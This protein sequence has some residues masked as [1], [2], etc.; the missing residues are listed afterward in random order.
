[1]EDPVAKAKAIAARMS[2][3]AA[4]IGTTAASSSLK[5][6]S[7]GFSAYGPAGEAA[8]SSEAPKRKRW[9]GTAD[10]SSGSDAG[11]RYGDKSAVETA[12]V[13]L[14]E[15]QKRLKSAAQKRV[16]VNVTGDRPAS[17]YRRYWN[18]VQKPSVVN[19]E[20]MQVKLQGR[21]SSGQPPLP[22]VP[23]EPMHVLLE[24]PSAEALEPHVLSVEM[25]LQQAENAELMPDDEPPANDGTAGVHGV[26]DSEIGQGQPGA[27]GGS[28]PSFNTGSGG[29]GELASSGSA[30]RPAP[31][32][33]LIN[34][35]A[36]PPPSAGGDHELLNEQMSVPNGVVGYIIGRGGESISSM[37]ART[38]AKV[39]IQKERDMQPGQGLRI[40]TIQ[41]T[42]KEAIDACRSIIDTMVTERVRNNNNNNGGA[43]GNSTGGSGGTSQE[44]RLREAIA[45]GHAVVQ[46]EIP[47][48][49]VG[50]IIGRGGSTIK[51]IQ[52]RSGA[53]VQIPQAGDPS[54]PSVRTVNITH[55]SQDGAEMAKK[56]V[57]DILDSK[58]SNNHGGGP[59]IGG[60]NHVTVMVEIPD[61]DV[62]MCI[63]RGGCVIREMQTQTNT[64]IQI[65]SMS[66]PGSAVR[67]ATVMGPPEGCEKVKQ[68]I[69]RIVT[70][71]SSAGLM[72]TGYQRGGG[73]YG[74]SNVNTYGGG[75]GGGGGGG[76][77][78]G[79]YG[80]SNASAYGRGGGGGGYGN[81]YGGGG[82]GGYSQHHQPQYHQQ[83]PPTQQHQNYSNQWGG[84]T[85]AQQGQAA[86]TQPSQGSGAPT[87]NAAAPS[88]SNGGTDY[89]EQFHR[90]AYYYGEDAARKH[91]GAWAP[92]PGTPNPYG[93]NPDGIIPVPAPGAPG[94]S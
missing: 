19:E 7:T 6:G 3:D 13:Q 17:H 20:G 59:A 80:S 10:A 75:G 82:G 60:P 77:Y 37:Q 40:I 63:G 61:K 55:P 1:M 51:G 21:G 73:G 29:G 46:V 39:H 86:S 76:A 28:D 41:A 83:Q 38:G 54:N 22:G 23:E 79:G 89:T 93:V 44:A 14:E 71:Q 27:A 91:Y 78:N 50:L 48:A 74:S 67:I 9:G 69:H 2:S 42:T 62:G 92:P 84:Y 32:A 30:Y 88:G 58:M 26:T 85:G 87:N 18:E 11:G 8:A 68:M 64:K 15:T 66:T 52:D 33:A 53:N 34:P 81:N 5:S 56:M 12:Q 65:P 45:A 36:G 43:Y 49:D 57:Q 25:Y 72:S 47:D 24:G 94:A 16:W 35:S 90:Y 70:E 31:V 4:T